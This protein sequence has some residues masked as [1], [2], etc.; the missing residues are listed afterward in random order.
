MIFGNLRKY[1][2]D[3][4]KSSQELVLEISFI[5]LVL[6]CFVAVTVAARLL[7]NDIC[8]RGFVP[9]KEPQELHTCGTTNSLL[10]SRIH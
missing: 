1:S 2:D 7:K 6:A 5:V 4:W 8:F 3:L 10:L 9:H